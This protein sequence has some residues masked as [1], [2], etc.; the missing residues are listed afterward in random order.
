[1]TGY[2]DATAPDADAIDRLF[3][4]SFADTFGHLYAA[5]DLHAFFARCTP[6]AWCRELT[7]PG[8]AFRLAERNGA[9]VGYAKLGP[10]T[11]PVSPQGPALE[12]NQLYLA[13]QAKGTGVASELMAWVLATARARGAGELFLSVFIDNHRA[14]RF[15]ARYGFTDVGAYSFLVGSHVDEDRLMRLAL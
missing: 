14:K 3:R 1:M 10:I 7:T 12:L 5:H 6:D 11:L 15:Y 2:R 9:L 4:R 8:V 13:E